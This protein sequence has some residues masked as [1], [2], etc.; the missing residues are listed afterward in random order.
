MGSDDPFADAAGARLAKASRDNYLVAWRR[1]LG[2]L[3]IH[4]PTASEIPPAERLT[5]ERI[6]SFVAH[7]ARTN[8]PQSV[9]AGVDKLYHA[10][11]VMMPE[12]DWT[13]LKAVKAR[14]YRAAPAPAR[15]GPVITSIQLLDLGEQL[16]DESKSTPGTPISTG[17]AVR[18]RDGLM[19]ALLAFVRSDTKILL[20]LRS[21]AISSA[22]AIA[23][24]SLFHA[25]RQRRERPSSS[26]FPKC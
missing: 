9:A 2:F 12:R 8:S 16:M 4:E 14:L 21:I 23:G 1:F 5:V 10:A 25:R 15:R 24:L 17:D 26:K 22:R 13:W 19:V 11:R 3:A 20:R 6:R 18:Y 7:L